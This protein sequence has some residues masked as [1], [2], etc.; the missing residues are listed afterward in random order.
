[1]SVITVSATVE[2]S[3]VPPRVRLTVTDIGSPNLFAATVTRLD[4][5]GRVVV[6]RTQDGNPLTLTTSGSNRTG[7]VYDYEMP[8]GQPV[9]YSTQES[10][11]TTS[12]EVTVA[13]DRVWL[14]HPGVPA[15]S[16]PVSV[17][18]FGNL[19]RPVSRNVFRPMGRKSALVVTDGARKSP[20]G[21]VELN[22]FTLA[23]AAAFE[24]LTDDASVLLLNVPAQLPWGFPTSYVS[25][26]DIEEGRLVE[27][28]GEPRRLQTL[29]LVVVERPSGGSQAQRTYSDLLVYPTYTA[30]RSAY[31][32]YLDLLG[33]P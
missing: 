5:D 32:S 13:E 14:V 11:T 18:A 8:Y 10:P 29:P 23:E 31:A 1:M 12:G 3:N 2:L 15:L 4:P 24:A 19:V 25:L 33:G 21:T 30:L 17:A 26:G 20:E 7:I 9:T 6:V 27:Y 22:T 16:M 28:A